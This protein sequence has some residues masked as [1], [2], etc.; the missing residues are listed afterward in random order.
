MYSHVCGYPFCAEGRGTCGYICFHK[1]SYGGD[2]E[3][4]LSEFQRVDV[5][6]VAN[7]MVHKEYIGSY[8]NKKKL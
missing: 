3:T 2:I 6:S 5:S 8:N 4:V 1:I 7:F